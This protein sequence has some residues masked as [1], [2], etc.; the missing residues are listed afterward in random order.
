MLDLKSL[1]V[2]LLFFFRFSRPDGLLLAERTFIQRFHGAPLVFRK[3]LVG[4]FGSFFRFSPKLSVF[5]QPAILCY[6]TKT[7]SL[8]KF[9]SQ[10]LGCV[11]STRSNGNV[12]GQRPI[13][14]EHLGIY[15]KETMTVLSDLSHLKYSAPIS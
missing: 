11:I 12:C 9:P 14:K 1:T 15:A 10:N 8:R 13:M 7:S 6:Q 2:T 4:N 5:C 3:V